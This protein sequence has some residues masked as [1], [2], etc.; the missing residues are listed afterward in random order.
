MKGLTGA[1]KLV[2]ISEKTDPARSVFSH[3][4]KEI[5]AKSV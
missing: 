2:S 5:N 4:E 3:L 1:L